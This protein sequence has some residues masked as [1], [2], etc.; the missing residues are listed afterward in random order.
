MAD[1]ECDTCLNSYTTLMSGMRIRKEILTIRHI[2]EFG[3]QT[4]NVCRDCMNMS[5]MARA[6][7]SD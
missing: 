5:I 2:G 6:E 4:I 1:N 7:G 3:P